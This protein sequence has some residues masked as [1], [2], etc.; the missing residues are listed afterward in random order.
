[1]P[2]TTKR[3]QARE[4]PQM[5][6]AGMFQPFEMAPAANERRGVL[7]PSVVRRCRIHVKPR[8]GEQWTP[9]ISEQETPNPILK[10][11]SFEAP[12]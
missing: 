9:G 6:W 5:Q 1:M 4:A 2:G 8:V 7:G 11:T 12:S 3:Y 10:T